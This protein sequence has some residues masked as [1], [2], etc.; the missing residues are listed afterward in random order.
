MAACDAKAAMGPSAARH[1]P[2]DRDSR[3]DASPRQGNDEREVFMTVSAALLGILLSLTL[4]T[5]ASAEI[6]IRNDPGGQVAAYL[7]R[8]G[9]VRN[10]GERVVIDGTCNSACTLLL[11]VVPR[12]RI[13]VTPR[14]S[15]GFHAASLYD[16]A[17]RQLVPSRSGTRLVLSM[18]P[19]RVRHWIER[20]GGL[21]PRLLRLSGPELAAMY[22]PC[23]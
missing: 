1:A 12:D 18:Y 10:S 15:L 20:H 6:R 11:G 3:K 22:R 19:R 21:T 13:C 16:D 23:R 17:S 8:F 2:N 14:A 9:Q 5:S 4:A 7:R